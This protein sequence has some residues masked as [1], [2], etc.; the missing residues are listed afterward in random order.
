MG[1]ICD[2]RMRLRSGRL[3]PY[4]SRQSL[5]NYRSS[6]KKAEEGNNRVP[7][8]SSKEGTELYVIRLEPSET[9]GTNNKPQHDTQVT[10]NQPQNHTQGTKRPRDD[11]NDANY[12]PQPTKRQR[13]AGCRMN[14]KKCLK[15]LARCMGCRATRFL[16]M[17]P[18]HVPV[19]VRCPSVPKIAPSPIDLKDF[20]S[21]SVFMLGQRVKLHIASVFKHPTISHKLAKKLEVAL[22]LISETKPYSVSDLLTASELR[23]LDQA[24][25]DK[26]I[27]TTAFLPIDIIKGVKIILTNGVTL[28]TDLH[29]LPRDLNGYAK[30][31]FNH[32]LV[33]NH[34][35]LRRCGAVQCYHD[36]KSTL[37]FRRYDFSKS[38]SL[39]GKP[40]SV[41]PYH[42]F[43]LP[44]H[45][46]GA[47][48]KSPWITELV[49]LDIIT[50][51][52]GM[53]G[54][55]T[56]EFRIFITRNIYM[57][58]KVEDIYLLKKGELILGRNLLIKYRAI[59]DYSMC[60]LYLRSKSRWYRL[61]MVGL[62]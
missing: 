47:P 21:M 18:E 58:A 54:G 17:Y 46:K 34:S 13:T 62:P 28:I 59:L 56:D 30:C 14:I 38:N 52:A 12:N 60:D 53:N 61:K 24:S 1:K 25:K 51:K 9:Q 35:F 45:I 42:A 41:N 31:R 10:N 19:E 50:N 3:K 22:K 55:D 37:H 7:D 6:L 32:D 57:R 44:V 36:F 15:G 33:L 48:K 27:L 40:T 8:L 11:S 43:G 39:R 49:N 23:R 4:G 26:S 16:P 2:Y 5:R 20:R 29:I